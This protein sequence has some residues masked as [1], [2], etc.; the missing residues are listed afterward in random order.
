MRRHLPILAGLLLVLALPAGAATLQRTHAMSD[1]RGYLFSFRFDGPVTQHHFTLAGP[2]RLVIDVAASRRGDGVAPQTLE[3]GVVRAIRYGRRPDGGLRLVIDLD[4]P[5][6]YAV[7]SLQG[8][9]EV[10][11]VTLARSPAGRFVARELP[12]VAPPV[13]EERSAGVAT[14]API[15]LEAA[16]EPPRETAPPP[17]T[18]VRDLK[19][20]EVVEGIEDC[21]A[22]ID[23]MATVTNNTYPNDAPSPPPANFDTSDPDSVPLDVERP[24]PK[25]DDT[26]G[27]LGVQRFL[28]RTSDGKRRTDIGYR[29]QFGDSEMGVS[30]LH[31]ALS[32]EHETD[33]GDLRMLLRSDELHFGYQKQWQ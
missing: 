32:W 23:E 14:A 16:P 28:K 12:A 24:R 17:T 7:G 10:V 19:C 8:E 20:M 6:T 30:L 9:P 26:H 4:A 27:T 31:P 2:D 13:E 3:G 1:G 15:P 5:V 18:T 21:G 33:V 22:L 11:R 25:G 29:T